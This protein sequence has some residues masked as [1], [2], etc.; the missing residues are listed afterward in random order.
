MEPSTPTPPQADPPPK[1]GP[2][3][4]VAEIDLAKILG[5]ARDD[6]K[7]LRSEHLTLGEHYVRGQGQPVMITPA[8]QRL[9]GEILGDQKN[10]PGLPTALDT[11]G[12]AQT[13]LGEALGFSDAL[14]R[15]AEPVQH[16]TLKVVAC[17]V[18]RRIVL[19]KTEGGAEVRCQVKLNTNFREGMELKE[20]RKDGPTLYTY[21]GRLPRVKGKW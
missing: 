9:L 21:Q 15:A 3:K 11:V 17:C 5:V 1:N 8:G 13:G 6:L 20:C 12:I 10:G 2:E 16:E 14:A 18:N 19:C 7:R 4:P